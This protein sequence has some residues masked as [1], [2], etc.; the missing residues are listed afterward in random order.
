[1]REHFGLHLIREVDIGVVT[2]GLIDQGESC[3]VG[4]G[5]GDIVGDL[6]DDLGAHQIVDESMSSLWIAGILGDHQHVVEDIAALLGDH[7][8]ELDAILR[9]FG[10]QTGLHHIPGPADG[11]TDIAIGQIIDV[12]LEKEISSNENCST[13]SIT[14]REVDVIK[15]LVAGKRPKEIAD[16]LNISEKTVRNHISNTMQKL[17]V[18]GRAQAVVELIRL[19]EISL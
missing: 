5:I 13:G 11:H 17:S 4:I 6:G 9:L 1:M 16:I 12:L 18:K 14:E 15:E 19:G 8:V 2:D 7:I 3:L 10:A